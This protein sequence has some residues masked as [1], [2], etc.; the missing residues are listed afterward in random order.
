MQEQHLDVA[1][2]RHGAAQ[3]RL[4]F[5]LDEMDAGRPAERVGWRD[6]VG[7]LDGVA[8]DAE[9][10]RAGMRPDIVAQLRA[11]AGELHAAHHF[12]VIALGLS[13]TPAMR[14]ITATVSP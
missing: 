10:A 4:E 3:H 14:S 12:A 5:R 8:V 6:D 9:I 7:L 11:D 2:P 1:V 13:Y